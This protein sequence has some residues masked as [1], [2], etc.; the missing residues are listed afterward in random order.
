[1]RFLG[2]IW[3][4]MVFHG[5]DVLCSSGAAPG[6]TYC[7]TRL[8]LWRRRLFLSNVGQ[9]CCCVIYCH[10]KLIW[11]KL[12]GYTTYY[13]ISLKRTVRSAVCE[14]GEEGRRV[15]RLLGVYVT[16]SVCKLILYIS[17]LFLLLRTPNV[18]RLPSLER[19]DE[20]G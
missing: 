1:M 10:S 12:L 14:I 7:R 19:G 17:L 11:S 20:R 5:V 8:W 15:C 4:P 13:A 16:S 2:L 6:A 3:S 9:G 18:I